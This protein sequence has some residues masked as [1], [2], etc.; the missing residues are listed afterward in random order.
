MYIAMSHLL[1]HPLNQDR[2]T[3]LV[4]KGL[5]WKEVEFLA[6]E[7]GLTLA[8]FAD[9]AGISQPT[10]FRRR[11][12]KRFPLDE[13]DHIMRFARLWSLAVDV[14]EREDGARE[15]LKSE[16]FGLAGKVPLDVARSEA[17]ARVVETLL[18]RIDYGVS[19]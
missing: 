10:F 7:L 8:Q 18:Q 13:S 4:E 9:Y 16:A 3:V 5:P 17:G 1:A 12:Q 2:A 15:W 6:G 19:A 14:F 11:R